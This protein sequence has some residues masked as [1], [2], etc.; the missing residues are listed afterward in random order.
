MTKVTPLAA[1]AVLSCGLALVAA[2]PAQAATGQD[3][4]GGLARGY[5][6]GLKPRPLTLKPTGKKP[7]NVIFLV[8]DALRP[9]HMGVYG[10]DKAREPTTPF[11]D[12]WSQDAFV[13]LHHH[14][15]APW[16][17][18]STASMLTGLYPSK[19]RTQTDQSKLPAGI[20][21]LPMDMKRLGYQTVG[22]VGNGNGSSIGGL[23][24][25]FEHYVDTTTAWE[26]LPNA[27]QIFDD[28]LAWTDKKR[29]KNKPFF[30]FLFV[31]DPHDPYRAPPEYEKRFLP[32][33]FEG[34]PRR[35]AHWEYK[36]DYPK[37]ERDSMLAVYDAAIRY[38]DDQI[39]RFFGELE[40]RGLMDDTTI[41]ITADH[42][43]G[44]G[45][46]GYY[47]HAHHHYDEIIRVPLLVKTPAY[48]GGGMVF[49]T[50]QAVDLLPSLVSLAGGKPRAE[51]PGK[52]VFEMLQSPV[53]PARVALT[54]YNAFGI[55][56]SSIYNQR[57]RVIL[58]LPADEKEFL[59]HIPRKELLPSVNFERE[60]LHV[61]DRQK[62]PRDANNI[63]GKGELPAEA[64]QLRDTLKAW[65][66]SAPKPNGDVDVKKLNPS[67]LQ[68]LRD[69]GYVQ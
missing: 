52:P 11:L 28:A 25:G 63:A 19:H 59:K 16:T 40:K 57:Y 68:D 51:L 17:R 38:T 23:D 26:K 12:E 42:G 7:G 39:K 66:L 5:F 34:E 24:R 43:D 56:R 65:M 2:A 60:V 55:R 20:R 29:K 31:V 8:V 37:H 22:V 50:T 18:P 48:E 58:Q 27:Q 33:G 67:A 1:A 44:F 32:P 46:H 30:M 54:E 4:D 3:P 14:V 64:A 36:N 6:D 21:T 35:R 62:D 49:H 69:L 45:E 13:F 53:D 10:Y 47:L 9:D 41:V 15:N 61:Y